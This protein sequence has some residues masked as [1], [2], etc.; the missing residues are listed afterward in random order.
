MSN[1]D[2]EVWRSVEA[3]VR[4]EDGRQ[5]RAGLPPEQRFRALHPHSAEFIFL[6]ALATRARRI[7]EVGTSAGYSALWLAR[8][9]AATGGSLV[10]LERN[11]DIIR[12]AVDHL[13]SAGVADLVEIRA[14]DARDT[15][16]T[17]DEP[18]DFAF[19]DGAKDEYVAYGELLWPRLAVGASLVADN[20]LS[21]A[22]EA[23]PFL[24]WLRGLT[25]AATTVLEIGNGLSWTVKG[26]IG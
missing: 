1:F 21:H 20:V 9:C 6:L 19:V 15:L 3:A 13:K 18:F 7:V 24:G 14:G 26:D 5:R 11:P 2:L 17:F 4:L 22:G 8:A 25:G 12:V 10:T 23:A 16:A